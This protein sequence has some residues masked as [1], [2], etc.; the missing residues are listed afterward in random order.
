MLA[1]SDFGGQPDRLRHGEVKPFGD[2]SKRLNDLRR[3]GA[4]GRK[5]NEL[6]VQMPE[7][8][9]DRVEVRAV[10]M[11]PSLDR[12]AIH[13]RPGLDG[14]IGLTLATHLGEDELHMRADP[15]GNRDRRG[16]AL[17]WLYGAAEG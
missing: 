12:R 7:H 17:L 10:L 6:E 1:V 9:F 15:L 14:V 11:A 2:R 16:P 13:A 8:G 4:P 5:R 3:Q